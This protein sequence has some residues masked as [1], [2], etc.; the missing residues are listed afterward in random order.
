M[1]VAM[2]A[3]TL[4][5]QSSP[6][7]GRE[8]ELC[9]VTGRLKNPD[10][11][12]LTMVGPGGVGKTHLAVEAASRV[13]EKF[14]NGIIFVDLQPVEGP[15]FITALAESLPLTLSGS[16]DPR[17][18]VISY[19][20]RKHVLLLLDNFEHLLPQADFLANLLSRSSP[21]K[22][23]VT[24]REALQLQDEWL[25]PLHGL[26]VPPEPP[27][28]DLTE[29]SAVHLFAEHAQRLNP[30]FSL[31]KE[32]D[33]AAR[34]CRLVEGLPLAL[35]LAASWTRAVDCSQIADEIQRNLHFLAR[36]LRDMPERH[37]S[38]Q[39]T[40]NQTWDKLGEEERRV[41]QELSLF[42]GGFHR[43]AAQE[44]AGA[45]LEILSTLV[46][47]SMLRHEG[48]YHIHELLR[49]FGEEKLDRSPGGGEAVCDRYIKYYADFL[50]QR[51]E[52]I[53]GSTQRQAASEI[54]DEWKNIRSAWQR[55]VDD[56]QADAIHR[57]ATTF[58][59]F[60]QIQSRFLEG[61][62]ALRAAAARVV[63][64]AP[65]RDRD[66]TLATLYNHEGWLRIRVGEFKRA[67]S[68]LEKSLSLYREHHTA[69]PSYMGSDSTVPLAIT[70][71]IQGDPARAIKLCE[72]ALQEA[73]TRHDKHN[74]AF[75][76][77]SLAAAHTSQGEYNT[78]YDHARQAC[79]AARETGNRWFLAYPLI[80][81]GNAA[82]AMNKFNEAEKHYRESYAIK[83]TFDDP[84]G[85][86]VALNHLGEIAIQKDRYQEARDHLRRSLDLYRDLN[87]RGGL[88]RS[89]QGLGQVA[90]AT[91]DIPTASRYFRRALEIAAGIQFQ[92]LVFS[93]VVETAG[94]LASHDKTDLAV[95]LLSLTRAHSSSKHE[96][97]QHADQLLQTY[98]TK[99]PDAAFRAAR[100]QGSDWNLDRALAEIEAELAAL[101]GEVQDTTTQ[102]QPLVEPLT[103]RELDVLRL[104]AEG[105]TNEEISRELVL[106]VGTVKWYASQI[107]G[108]LGVSN[109]TEA[110][111][112]ARKLELLS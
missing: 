49:Q 77:Y 111:V 9:E 19:L 48:R 65:S 24:S 20:Q 62:D 46:D 3:T 42:K 18:Q 8:Q 21:S 27:D 110:A 64:Q 86:A 53:N 105:H 6:L 22:L 35:K 107:Y 12:L 36:P 13:G 87:D 15:D 60:C 66:L 88:A 52:A 98:Q 102:D 26:A 109:R 61:A 55:A 112:R 1:G 85:M 75:A 96:S 68:I 70:A 2:T 23:F 90:H 103:S 51:L 93:I 67:Q 33:G 84:E 11:R 5:P 37:R 59:L 101:F 106:A 76:H 40:F 16:K 44:I 32:G 100:Q 14:K 25:Y 79:E 58:F 45:N 95:K 7:I 81:W 74:Q 63:Q 31:E 47:K 83:E 28:R 89:L 39:A 30:D 10:C 29:Y 99:M 108:K 43:E 94:L 50:H 4:P 38:I 17:D 71:T 69:P 82:R 91:G 80:E 57:S 41:F 72:P 104:I 54:D 56:R 34:I 73:E 97:K 92:P 78:A